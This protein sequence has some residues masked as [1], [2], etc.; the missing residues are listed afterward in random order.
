MQPDPSC[1][2]IMTQTIKAVDLLNVDRPYGPRFIDDA[3]PQTGLDGIPAY[4]A[5][6]EKAVHT[7]FDERL[8]DRQFITIE[9]EDG[10]PDRVLEAGDDIVVHNILPGTDL[11]S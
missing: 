7:Y 9:F 1:T 5:R 10:T 4:F 6:K 8:G 11:R 3:T 2:V